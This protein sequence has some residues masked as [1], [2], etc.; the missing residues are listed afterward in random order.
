[1]DNEIKIAYQK[2]FRD[3]YT[4]QELVVA[5]NVIYLKH[6]GKKLI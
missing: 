6:A 1:M 5:I 3:V 4:F 2:Y